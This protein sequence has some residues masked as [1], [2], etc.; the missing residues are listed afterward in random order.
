M[1]TVYKDKTQSRSPYVRKVLWNLKTTLNGRWHR[2]QPDLNAI[3]S[4]CN[5]KWRNIYKWKVALE[6]NYVCLFI[7]IPTK[8]P[9]WYGGSW[10]ANFT[11]KTEHFY[12]CLH[13]R[14]FNIPVGSLWYARFLTDCDLLYMLCCVSVCRY[15]VAKT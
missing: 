3:K 8:I 12:P 14:N 2:M 15:W 4:N 10:K 9:S 7:Y 6:M 1:G 11:T 13:L 5:L